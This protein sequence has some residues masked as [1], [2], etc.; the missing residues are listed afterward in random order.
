MEQRMNR[1]W[2]SAFEAKVQTYVDAGEAVHADVR[3]E[4]SGDPF[5]RLLDDAVIDQ[6]SRD[7]ELQMM[8]A[9]KFMRIPQSISATVG[10]RT[11]DGRDQVILQE[12][13]DPRQRLAFRILQAIRLGL[14]GSDR[15]PHARDV[16]QQL[17]TES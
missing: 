8:A 17:D 12:V 10:R 14:I 4:Y 13:F 3:A 11:S 6:I 1:S 5:A 15:H 2:F 7:P 9:T 16:Y